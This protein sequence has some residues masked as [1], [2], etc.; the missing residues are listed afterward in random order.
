[1]AKKTELVLA[2]EVRKGWE[3]KSL[4][5]ADGPVPVVWS[6]GPG[7]YDDVYGKK[8][9]EATN[10]VVVFCGYESWAIIYAWTGN[11]VEKIWIMD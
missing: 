9:I 10:P 11:R 5:N 8:T 7:K 6:E 1:V 3:T 2:H 4:A